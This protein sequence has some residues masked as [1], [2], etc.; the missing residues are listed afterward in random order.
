MYGGQEK[1]HHLDCFVKMRN[2]LEF[3]DDGKALPGFESLSKE[4]QE[5]ISKSLPKIAP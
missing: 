2:Q 5:I 1:W 3:W 4:H